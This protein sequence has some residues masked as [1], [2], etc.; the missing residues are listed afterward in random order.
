MN[1]ELVKLSP[2]RIAGISART[3]NAEEMSGMSD[4]ISSLWAR[5]FREGIIDRIENRIPDTDIYG[6]YS[7]YQSDAGGEYTLTVGVQV[8]ADETGGQSLQQVDIEP[9]EYL[10]FSGTGEMPHVVTATWQA[11]WDHFSGSQE[12]RRTFTTDFERYPSD[13]EVAIHIGV[14][15]ASSPINTQPDQTEP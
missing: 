15:R 4:K 2:F 9:G 14:A 3:T 1:P 10:V 5:F 12:Y 6:V 8:P 7:D 13:S 11:V